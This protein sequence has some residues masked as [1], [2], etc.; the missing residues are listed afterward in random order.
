MTAFLGCSILCIFLYNRNYSNDRWVAIIIGYLGTMQLL[1]YLMW[2]DQE[3]T[4]LNQIA[5]NI[6]FV[7]NILQPI[8]SFIVAYTM[9]PKMPYWSYLL[10]L[11]YLVYSLPKIS[12]KKTDNQCSKPCSKENV[13][14]SWEY[15][16]TDNSLSVWMIFA[17]ALSA[18]FL[19]MNKNGHIYFAL[20]I[21]TYVLSCFI[22]Q[23]RCTGSVIPSN[24]SWWCLMTTVIPF[25]AIFINK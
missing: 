9:T 17:L 10:L 13:G 20:L 14:L 19:T 1:E 7:H 11:L 3:C 8:L 5:T 6:G 12:N 2:I 21:G 18:P 22:A 15:T 24:G 4:G 23:T 16:N 25:L